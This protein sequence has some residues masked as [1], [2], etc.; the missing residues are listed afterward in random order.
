M[1]RFSFNYKK[2]IV[3]FL[4]LAVCFN[5]SACSGI[6]ENGI[7]SNNSTIDSEDNSLTDDSYK[8]ASNSSE[9]MNNPDK[10]ED[11]N[12]TDSK[13]TSNEDKLA[14]ENASFTI[15][16]IS[17]ANNNIS[18]EFANWLYE[19][20]KDAASEF[21]LRVL[22]D[23]NFDPDEKNRIKLNSPLWRTFFN[24]SY[25]VLKDEYKGYLSDK[26][27][28]MKNNI[29]LLEAKNYDDVSLAF[30]GDICFEDGGYPGYNWQRAGIKGC[31]SKDLIKLMKDSDMFMANNEFTL[32]DRGKAQE[33]KNYTFRGNPSRVKWIKK[34]GVDVLSVANNHAYDYGVE[35]F[36]DTYNNIKN[37]GIMPVGGGMD[38]KEATT[39]KYVIIGGV[40]IALIAATQIEN[41]GVIQTQP[42]TKTSPG[43][44]RCADEPE[45]TR[46]CKMIK[47]ANKNSDYVIVY[48]H[49]GIE[50]HEE[51]QE[52][53]RYL[54]KAFANAGADIILGGH[55]HC[56]QGVE[57]FG[58]TVC[59]Y[60]LSNFIFNLRQINEAVITVNLKA[61]KVSEIK[62]HP[63]RTEG[64]YTWLCKKGDSKYNNIMSIINKNSAKNAQVTEDGVVIKR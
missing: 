37:A 33:G 30:A 38:I 63:C 55:P 14:K 25:Y 4:S 16:N 2:Y 32:S 40:K 7:T 48:P 21:V 31:F 28:A 49:W 57:H 61:G 54:A 64:A 27:N 24:K 60:S 26:E 10:S 36:I 5:I 43:V 17:K 47:K 20:Y 12:A 56:V 23:D 6:N 44:L 45:I 9:V 34:M 58:D 52:N 35:S 19:N 1:K 22:A 42:A 51:L 53:Q 8:D 18:E 41:W 50:Y 15:D 3:L 62:Y 29:L 39:V 46:V 59:C 11:E 13:S